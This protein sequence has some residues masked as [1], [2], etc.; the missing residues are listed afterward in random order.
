MLFRSAGAGD[1]PLIFDIAG[2]EIYSYCE[3][4]RAI[5]AAIGRPARLVHLPAPVV[6][7]LSRIVGS[8]TRDVLVN[9]EEL[10]ALR[11]EL[12]LSHEAPRARGGFAAWL[13]GAGPTLG[14][15]YASE[16]ERNFRSYEPV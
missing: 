3:L 11:A 5:A 4:A 9:G 7:T 10:G 15:R 1:S 6:T 8:L 14:R 2:P 13:A 16:L 12:L